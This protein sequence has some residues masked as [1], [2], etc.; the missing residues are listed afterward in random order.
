MHAL[1]A[2]DSFKVTVLVYNDLDKNVTV[3]PEYCSVEW[4]KPTET[5]GGYG[6][7]IRGYGQ[8]NAFVLSPG[9]ERELSIEAKVG[10]YVSTGT[11]E[12]ASISL[13]QTGGQLPSTD[14]TSP[15]NAKEG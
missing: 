6:E 13:N 5:A 3:Q 11:W 14:Y 4:G 8:G 12:L 2:G 15:E 10:S 9:G 7:Y 1:K